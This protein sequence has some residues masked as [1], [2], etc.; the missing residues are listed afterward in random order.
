MEHDD[1]QIDVVDRT[2]DNGFNAA[3]M[4]VNQGAVIA[5][6]VRRM[7]NCILYRAGDR[8]ISRLRI[9][10]HG[11]SGS[12][13][14][15]GGQHA[16]DTQRIKIDNGGNLLNRDLLTLLAGRFSANALV[17]LHGCSVGS[18]WK[19]RALVRE[20]ANLWDARVQAALVVQYADE[21]NV[22]EGVQYVEADGRNNQSATSTLHNL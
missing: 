5:P 18:G 17:Q 7:V 4:R 13:C 14:V 11:S 19:G 10:G 12:Q 16:N 8:L 2:A 9:F 21:A 1:V 15:S 22:F 3:Q 6:D 20:L